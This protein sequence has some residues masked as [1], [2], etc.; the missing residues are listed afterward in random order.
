M[1]TNSYDYY[2]NDNDNDNDKFKKNFDINNR[3]QLL[4][5]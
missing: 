5:L 3:K 4:F 1:M 2:N